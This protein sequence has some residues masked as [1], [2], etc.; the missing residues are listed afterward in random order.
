[1]DK[2]YVCRVGDSKTDSHFDKTFKSPIINEKYNK[3]R[4]AFN[5]CSISKKMVKF[6]NKSIS[7]GNNHWV[8]FFQNKPHDYPYAIS[9]FKSIKERNLGPL[10]NI[11]ETNDERGWDKITSCGN[12]DFTYDIILDQIY[13]LNRESFNR[14]KLKGQTT[15]FEIKSEKLCEDHVKL[16]NE[17]IKELPYIIRYIEP[18]KCIY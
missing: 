3:I 13:L 12:N 8:I 6:I 10:I 18:I 4:W 9:S 16:Y 15:F 1:M 14:C 11:D 17:V 2:I 5:K 7:E